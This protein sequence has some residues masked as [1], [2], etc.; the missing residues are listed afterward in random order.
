MCENTYLYYKFLLTQFK[1]SRILGKAVPQHTYGGIGGE[2]AQL[3]LIHYLDT[4]YCEWSASRPRPHFTAW[5]M[6]PNTH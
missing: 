4:R 3:L 1:H 2:D 6:T 5:K